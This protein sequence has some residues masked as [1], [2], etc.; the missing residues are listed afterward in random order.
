MASKTKKT[1]RSARAEVGARQ[2][3]YLR[4]TFKE[5]GISPSGAAVQL[6]L[7][8][9]TFT[10]FMK[11]PETSEKTLSARTIARVEELRQ[12]NSDSPIPTS[13]QGVWG[14]LHEEAVLL[15]QTHPDADHDL[16]QAI[17]M[18]IGDRTGIAPWVIQ[19]RALELEGFM[20]GDIVLVDENA[21][22]KPGDAVY[23]VADARSSRPETLM[24]QYQLVGGVNLLV[25]RTMDPRPPVSLVVDNSRVVIR[26]VLLP[27]RLRSRMAA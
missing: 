26:G 13:A 3:A 11:L 19:T 23:A 16:M 5:L 18:L 22:P 1:E 21:S 8:P 2:R 4:D 10:R 24:R 17:Q 14:T 27:H 6:E 9:S 12:A 20:P 15:I 25:A 7:S